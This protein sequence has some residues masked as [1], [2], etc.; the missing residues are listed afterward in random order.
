M[1]Y[2]IQYIKEATETEKRTI[3]CDL[4]G[5]LA[6]Y[7][8][9]K[10]HE[11]IGD[12]IEKTIKKLKKE[13]EKGSKIIIHTARIRED[14]DKEFDIA[15][16]VEIISNWLTKNNVPHDEIWQDVGKPIADEYWDDRAVVIKETVK[17]IS[18]LS[19]EGPPEG[20]YAVEFLLTNDNDT[21]KEYRAD[22]P[23]GT[24]KTFKMY[25]KKGW[26]GKAINIIKPYVK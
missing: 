5:T 24:I 21:K 15:K 1:R 11:S 23:Q 3:A 4:D 18:I 2:L 9:W 7:S 26:Y 12:P 13:K 17:K 14:D 6:K 20:H 16:R 8:G 22:A 10:G 19:L 25:I